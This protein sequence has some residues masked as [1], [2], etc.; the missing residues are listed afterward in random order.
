MNARSATRRVLLCAKASIVVLSIA[1]SGRPEGRATLRDELR[2]L[3]ENI[4]AVVKTEQQPSIAVGDFI[5]QVRFDTAAGPG[6]SEDLKSILQELQAG[7]VDKNAGL[8]VSG[9][10]A[11]VP[12]QEPENKALT[13]NK[14]AA[15]N[16]DKTGRSIAEKTVEINSNKAIAQV[17]AVTGA[18]SKDGGK[19][20]RNKE[21]QKAVE[22]PGFFL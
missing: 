21:L 20:E 13:I 4:L 3:A 7:V 5:G 15:I 6:I 17:M 14:V 16:T 10:Y 8:E 18:L 12:G 11:Y 2:V 9:R 19:P 22:T 1:A